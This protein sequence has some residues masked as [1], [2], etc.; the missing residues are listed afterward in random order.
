M[1]KH[2]RYLKLAE[3]A[4]E[5]GRYADD[6]ELTAICSDIARSWLE[7]ARPL[8]PEKDEPLQ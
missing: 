5:L 4:E 2:E 8:R 3:K 1:D 6:P 7:L